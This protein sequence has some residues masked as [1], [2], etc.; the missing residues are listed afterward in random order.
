VADTKNAAKGKTK[1]KDKGKPSQAEPEVS[2]K[3]VMV[4]VFFS[5]FI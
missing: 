4:K 3:S 5:F 1:G 2:Y